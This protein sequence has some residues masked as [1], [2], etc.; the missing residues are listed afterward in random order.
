MIRR[1]WI[2]AHADVTQKRQCV[3]AGMAP[4]PNTSAA[5]PK[6][7]VHH[8]LA[9]TVKGVGRV[10]LINQPL[11]HLVCLDKKHGFALDV[12]RRARDASEHALTL[13]RDIGM[14]ADPSMA[15]HGRLI[16]DFF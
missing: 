10:L 3:L 4:G 9:A 6:H 2:G 11:E 8:H 14:G 5:H 1:G 16:P 7:Q 13:L 12:D 15:D